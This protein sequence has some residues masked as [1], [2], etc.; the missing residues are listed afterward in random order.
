MSIERSC[1][2]VMSFARRAFMAIKRYCPIIVS[3][4]VSDYSLSTLFAYFSVYRG[5]ISGNRASRSSISFKSA[6]VSLISAAPA[7]SAR[8][9]LFFVPGIGIILSPCSRIHARDSCAG[10]QF[11]P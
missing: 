4:A 7:F 5:P 1:L 11:L 2:N 3:I 9:F 10:V 6:D 8:Y